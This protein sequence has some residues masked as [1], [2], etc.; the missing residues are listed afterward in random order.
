MIISI[1][2]FFPTGESDVLQASIRG[3]YCNFTPSSITDLKA[4]YFVDQNIK[5]LRVRKP[6]LDIFAQL[7][8]RIV[9]IVPF[10][11]DKYNIYPD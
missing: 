5:I 8:N 11:S 2:S 9:K 4:V 1:T 6:R 7:L 3:I 10:F